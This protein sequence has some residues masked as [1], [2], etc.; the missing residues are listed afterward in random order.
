MSNFAPRDLTLFKR[1][2]NIPCNGNK[3]NQIY[4]LQITEVSNSAKRPADN[5][6]NRQTVKLVTSKKIANFFRNLSTG[7]IDQTHSLLHSERL[8]KFRLLEIK[9]MY[10]ARHVKRHF[11][12]DKQ[13]RC[14]YKLSK[15]TNQR[16]YQELVYRNEV[17]KTIIQAL[18][19]PPLSLWD[20]AS[21]LPHFLNRPHWQGIWNRLSTLHNGVWNKQG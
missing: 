14:W 1:T 19:W 18:L 8:S 7:Q 2:L 12:S 9:C 20:R 11:A 15:V 5:S 6:G 16:V 13:T 17:F 4:T 3:P 10:D 21:G